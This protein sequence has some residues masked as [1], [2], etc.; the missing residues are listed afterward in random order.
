[1]LAIGILKFRIR[2]EGLDYMFDG[3]K[4]AKISY[5]AIKLNNISYIS[6]LPCLRISKVTSFVFDRGKSA[7]CYTKVHKNENEAIFAKVIKTLSD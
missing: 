4:A 2:N 6:C 7:G 1:M 3:G 5:G